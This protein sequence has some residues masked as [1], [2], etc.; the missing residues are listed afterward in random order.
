MCCFFAQDWQNVTPKVQLYRVITSVA[1]WRPKVALP[2][3]AESEPLASSRPVSLALGEASQ[4]GR[5]MDGERQS[6]NSPLA[7]DKCTN[8]PPRM[9]KIS[10]QRSPHLGGTPVDAS[11]ET[12][13][14][15]EVREVFE[16][17]F[18]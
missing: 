12:S 8:M 1:R 13:M 2:S 10:P 7:I 17:H 9:R 18:Q 14:P 15:E 16:L 6:G 3:K 5:F 11:F 4:R